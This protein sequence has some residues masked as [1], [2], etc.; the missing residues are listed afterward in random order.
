LEQLLDFVHSGAITVD[1]AMNK[2][3][4]LMYKDPTSKEVQD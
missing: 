3:E 4:R 1:Q 2:V